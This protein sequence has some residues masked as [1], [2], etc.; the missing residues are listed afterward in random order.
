MIFNL[1]KWK[2]TPNSD[3]FSG[4]APMQIDE[5]DTTVN[6][7]TPHNTGAFV[8]NGYKTP[9]MTVNL[10]V[11]DRPNVQD[12]IV[13][14]TSSSIESSQPILDPAINSKIEEHTIIDLPIEMLEEPT[15]TNEKAPLEGQLVINFMEHKITSSILGNTLIEGGKLVYAEGLIVYG[16]IQSA[17]LIVKGTLILDSTS[18]LED[19]TIECEQLFSLGQVTA[20]TIICKGLLVAWS[21]L[22]KAK[23]GIYHVALEKAKQCKISG[24]L[25]DYEGIR[26]E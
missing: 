19:V 7:N 11:I 9:K 12:V 8:Q 21:G 23:N 17:H 1:F 3:F 26:N 6:S 24:N 2:E 22:I 15:Q 10:P 16:K 25:L 20:N 18:V 5:T 14:N 13:S 4:K